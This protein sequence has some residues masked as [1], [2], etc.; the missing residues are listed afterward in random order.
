[1]LQSPTKQMKTVKCHE[2]GALSTLQVMQKQRYAQCISCGHVG[3]LIEG[4][5]FNEGYPKN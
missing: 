1:M 4:E 5:I 3:R 2:C